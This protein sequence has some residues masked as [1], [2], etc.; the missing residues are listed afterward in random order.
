MESTLAAAF[1]D[2]Q[3]D[4]GFFLGYGRD[5]EVWDSKKSANVT[6][7][8]K[9]GLRLVY[10]CGYP[11]SYLKPV[12]TLV[13]KNGASSAILPHDYGGFEGR[14][15]IQS[16]TSQA[17]WAL[18]LGSIGQIYERISLHP[19]TTG[20]PTMLAEE[21]IKGTT[22]TSGQRHQLKVWPIADQD[23]TLRF[24]Y[25]LLPDY[26]T[27]TQP[28]VYGGAQHAQ[29][30]FA[31]CKAVAERDLDDLA[32]G[33]QF[34]EFMRL[35]EVSKDLDRR[36]KPQTLGVNLDRSDWPGREYPNGRRFDGRITVNGIAY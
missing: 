4:V 34:I 2:L 20:R 27:G 22:A 18:E 10:H 17:W 26:L 19:S 23:Y 30:F 33:P 31:A 12:A 14:V 16:P 8:L 32:N 6:H 25:F 7:C 36:N 3:G 13:L 24:Q 15:T 11:W 1:T 29:L 35:L 21:P 9:G 5:P 28:Y